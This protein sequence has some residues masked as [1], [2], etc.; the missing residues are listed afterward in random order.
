MTIEPNALVPAAQYLRMSTEHQRYS[1]DN[2]RAAIAAYAEE[3]GYRIVSTY[4]DSGKSGLTLQGRDGLKQLLSDAVTG[5]AGFK[6]I[7]VLDVSRW[8]RFQDADQGSHYEWLCKSSGVAV[9]YV[10]EPFEQD[11]SATASII[12]Q[13][14]RVMAG[15]YSRE[16]SAKV[17]FA[18]TRGA[19]LGFLQGGIVPYGIRRMVVDEHGNPKGILQQG[20]WKTMR[21]DRI[22][23]VPGP[24]HEIHVIN[25]IFRLYLKGR[26][27]QRI[28]DALNREGVP[29]VRGR[30]WTYGLVYG[31]INRDW[32]L[33]KV[34]FGR[35]S[36]P[37]KGKWVQ[38]PREE[39]IQ[40]Q[41]FPPLVDPEI[42]MRAR[43]EGVYGKAAIID[44]RKL[45]R[46]LRQLHARHG[47][48][49]YAL[50]KKAHGVAHPNTYKKHFGTLDAAYRLIGLN[51]EE[52]TRIRRPAIHI[53]KSVLLSGLRRCYEKN[54]RISAK[55][56]DADPCIPSEH[57]YT[58][59]FGR[60]SDAYRLA[61]IPYE[62]RITSAAAGRRRAQ[63][64]RDDA[65]VDQAG[66]K[67]GA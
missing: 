19:S 35:T 44:N 21:S 56:V 55:L 47:R 65:K 60:L 43:S 30:K 40:V 23:P 4:I 57:T 37:L 36:K 31:L 20:E 63:R 13:L 66:S 7:L 5:N 16:L 45:L 53:R 51:R 26:S 46:D 54:G 61:G 27:C 8:G 14:K 9:H 17:L 62:D 28:A 48:V 59:I 18:Q 49:T 10:A 32:V 1:P 2:Q 24:Q 58:K 29:A 52:W 42:V 11:G 38:K 34:T 41:A 12:K 15:E 64:E 39:W 50:I 33:G 22:L 25:R 3:R 67:A 6:A